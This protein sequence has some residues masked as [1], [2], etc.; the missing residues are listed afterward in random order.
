M[1]REKIRIS[2]G[3]A[4][5]PYTQLKTLSITLK[6]LQHAAE[7][8][9]PHLVDHVEK[10]ARILWKEMVDTLS[11]ELEVTLKAL[12]WPRPDAMVEGPLMVDWESCVIN[13]L[14][15]QRP[16][17]EEQEKRADL[18][19]IVLLPLEVMVKPLELRFRYHFDSDRPTNRLDKVSSPNTYTSF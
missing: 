18:K 17:F 6:Q 12:D 1:T 14:D 2:P 13:L 16:D 3:A 10:A 19:E 8:A 5:E 15:L 7:D 11:M 4:L 9:A